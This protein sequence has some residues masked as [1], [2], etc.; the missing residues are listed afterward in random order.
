MATTVA[1]ISPT[2]VSTTQLAPLGFELSVSTANGGMKT[3]IYVE[4]D[5]GAD[6]AVGKMSTRK[7]GSATYQVAEAGAINPAMAVGVAQTLI[8][9]GSFGFVLRRGHGTVSAAGAV[10]A[11]KGLILGAS[12]N[13][14]HE[15][16]VT[17]SA[18]GN[19]LGG[20]AGPGAGTFTAFVN[21]LG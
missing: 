12:G 15:G 1:G 16:A 4:N 10:T 17:G 21:C 18:C 13:V 14:I 8:P 9:N 3:Y 11:N 19:T 7:A 5:S 20:A 2:T 6:L